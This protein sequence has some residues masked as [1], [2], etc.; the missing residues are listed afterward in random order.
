M[1]RRYR[2]LVIALFFSLGASC[3]AQEAETTEFEFKVFGVGSDHYE[4][5]YYYTGEVFELLEFH[6]THRSIRTY[7]Y[8][9]PLAFSIYVE[10][11]S[12]VATD[13]LSLPYIKISESAPPTSAKRQLI[14]F[15]A[16][17]LNRESSDPERRFT[18]Y[19]I[20]D[21]PEAFRRNTIVVIN[22]TRA[23]LYGSVADYRIN[24][25]TGHSRPIPYSSSSS[26]NAATNISFALETKNGAKLVMSNDLKIPNNRRVILILEPPRRPGS[27]RISVRMLSESIFL[28]EEDATPN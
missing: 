25:P 13:P 18:L 27:L 11:P 14:I 26:S 1:G 22:T 20:D 3:F 24:L 10:N 23:E 19:H 15:A 28:E 17:P 6:R 7:Q 16:S 12:Y 2:T 8:K 4:G 5:L 21:S 9:G